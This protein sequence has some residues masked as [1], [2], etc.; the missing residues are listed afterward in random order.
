[1]ANLLNCDI[2]LLSSSFYGDLHG[3]RSVVNIREKENPCYSLSGNTNLLDIHVS[4]AHSIKTGSFFFFTN[5]T[6]NRERA[7]VYLWV[8]ECFCVCTFTKFGPFFFVRNLNIQVSIC[9][10]ILISVSAYVKH[11]NCVYRTSLDI[12]PY[13]HIPGMCKS[14]ENKQRKK[15]LFK[16]EINSLVHS[17]GFYAHA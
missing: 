11:T 1:M 7:S 13:T 6:R 4:I 2:N 3:K 16:K 12:N 8:F 17:L 5:S 9:I 15:Y 14:L 10:H